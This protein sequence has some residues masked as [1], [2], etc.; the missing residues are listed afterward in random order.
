MLKDYIDKLI[1]VRLDPDGDIVGKLLA[2][3][4]SDSLN[5]L[6]VERKVDLLPPEDQNF[7]PIIFINMRYVISIER[8]DENIEET[9]ENQ[10]SNNGFDYG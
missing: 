8:I 7:D 1:Y 10:K 3:E 2:I 6:K 4:S 5:F 9:K